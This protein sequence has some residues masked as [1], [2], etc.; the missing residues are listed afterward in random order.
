VTQYYV[1]LLHRTPA[2]AEVNSWIVL[3]RSGIRDEQV[4]AGFTSSAE[5][6]AQV[7]GN[8]LAWVEA[9]Y[10]DFLSRGPD[11]AGQAAWLS[12]LATGTS[13]FTVAHGF[14]AS[15]EHRTRLVAG[16]YQRF[17]GRTADGSEVAGWVNNLERGLSAEQVIAAFLA[18]AEFYAGR[19]SSIEGW[20]EGVYQVLFER[21]PDPDGFNFWEGFVQEQTAGG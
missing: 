14:A 21:A 18:S 12:R 16:Y 10:R 13:R 5:Y 1:Q 9:L 19:A 8:D 6:Y 7:G 3:L 2:A 4:L 20:L 17:L 15:G 11:P